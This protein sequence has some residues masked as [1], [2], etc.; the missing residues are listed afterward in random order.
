MHTSQYKL[1]RF[2]VIN[3]KK[4]LTWDTEESYFL[5]GMDAARQG[6]AILPCQS[7]HHVLYQLPRKSEEFKYS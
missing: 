1:A 3:N 5:E 4:K 7:S 6:F 2:C